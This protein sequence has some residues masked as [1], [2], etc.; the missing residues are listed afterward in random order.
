M[1]NWLQKG[2]PQAK[3]SANQQELYQNGIRIKVKRDEKSGN[4]VV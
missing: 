4:V 1:T 2:D 3:N